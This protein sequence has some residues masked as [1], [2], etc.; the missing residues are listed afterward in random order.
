MRLIYLRE[1]NYDRAMAIFDELAKLGDD[2]AELR[3]FGLAG[4]CGVL[5]IRHRYEE[6]NAL[7]AQILPIQDKLKSE[8][9]RRL[10]A[11]A[12]KKNRSKLGEQTTRQWDK[13]LAEQFHDES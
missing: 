5:S 1:S 7:S 10:L 3:A 11:N 13:W 6:S 8:P 12:I 2:Q 9:M 4:Q